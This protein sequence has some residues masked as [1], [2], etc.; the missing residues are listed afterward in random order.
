MQLHVGDR[1]KHCTKINQY[2]LEKAICF[3][4]NIYLKLNWA[5]RR[6]FR[7]FKITLLV[8]TTTLKKEVA[9]HK[10]LSC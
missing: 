4:T 6:V 3:L 1:V 2:V 9:T 8:F 7:K 10:S 5:F